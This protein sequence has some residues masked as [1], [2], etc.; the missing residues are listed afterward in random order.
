MGWSI[1]IF[2]VKNNQK[3]KEVVK[4]LVK[5]L[6]FADAAFLKQLQLAM[7]QLPVDSELWSYDNKS[8]EMAQANELAESAV[9]LARA[10]YDGAEGLDTRTAV[11]QPLRLF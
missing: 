1:I 10:S 7:A 8:P 5:D 9:E 2:Y 3:S 11:K 6:D 4:T